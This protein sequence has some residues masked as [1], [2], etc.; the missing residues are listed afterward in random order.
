MKALDYTNNITEDVIAF[1]A[2]TILGLDVLKDS[3]YV[4]GHGQRTKLAST[5]GQIME[6]DKTDRMQAPDVW[7]FPRNRNLPAFVGEFKAYDV[8]SPNIKADDFEQEQRYLK[9]VSKFYDKAIGLIT[10]GY[11]MYIYKYV[12]GKHDTTYVLENEKELQNIMYYFELFDD[13]VLTG[14]YIKE[15]AIKLND[16]LHVNFCLKGLIDRWIITTCAIIA[17]MQKEGCISNKTSIGEIRSTITQ[18]LDEN[19][20]GNGGPKSEDPK[21]ML[22]FL[23]RGITFNI[24][25][26]QK[27]V[28]AYI[29]IIQ[30]IAKKIKSTKWNGDIAGIL[31]NEFTRYKD[32]SEQ[33][34]ILTPP[35]ISSLMCALIELQSDDTFVEGCVGTGSI[36]FTAAKIMTEAAGGIHTEQGKAIIKNNILLSD[37]DKDMCAMAF[38]NANIHKMENI[39]IKQLDATSEEYVKSFYDEN[40]NKKFNKLAMNPP[41]E[42]KYGCAKIIEKSI[43]HLKKYGKAI[44]LLPCNKLDKESTTAKRILKNNTLE[45]IIKLPENIFHGVGV[46]TSLFLFTT[47]VPHGNKEIFTTYIEDDGFVLTK[48]KGRCDENDTWK[49]IEAKYLDIVLKHKFDDSIKYKWI[50]STGSLSYKEDTPFELTE[51]DF[52][53]SLMDYALYANGIDSNMG[54]GHA[55][56]KLM[57]GVDETN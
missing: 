28:N 38:A 10:N 14:D 49:D 50:P 1:N 17:E 44:F 29:N 40:N 43:S 52:V 42:S 19:V 9:I 54:A 3:D 21:E 46:Q 39:N 11:N 18:V 24:A 55:L 35:H 15:Q 32:K 5:L 25:G 22:L 2:A 13:T 51:Y 45:A 30:S 6:L 7:A 56:T 47:G 41:Y 23:L 57:Y 34:Q 31:F 4:Y 53:K 48:N 8:K 37:K 20:C 12:K 27:D 16:L 33:G 36:G 26:V